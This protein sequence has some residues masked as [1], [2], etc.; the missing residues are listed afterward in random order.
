MAG[1]RICSR[2]TLWGRR[3]LCSLLL[4]LL[5][6]AAVWLMSNQPFLTPSIPD[7]PHPPEEPAA[8]LQDTILVGRLQSSLVRS[9][10][11]LR[12]CASE[13]RACQERSEG[14]EIK[15]ERE[16]EASRAELHDC[17]V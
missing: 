5:L 6:L 16:R 13:R 7:V 8:E 14:A 12:R 10:N 17:E 1:L 9:Q 11:E 3:A 15:M 4:L 2:V